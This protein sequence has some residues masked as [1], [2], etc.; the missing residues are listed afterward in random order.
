MEIDA[1]MQLRKYA[2]TMII[3]YVEDDLNTR[4]EVT[5]GLKKIFR[6]VE[7]ATNTNDGLKLYN[8][9]RHDI[10]ITDIE[11]PIMDGIEMVKQ[12]KIINK[13][14]IVAV[15][16]AY[17]HQKYLLELIEHGVDSFIMKP[18]NIDEFFETIHKLI[19]NK[20]YNNKIEELEKQINE[21]L[22]VEKKLLYSTLQEGE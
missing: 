14:Q 11:M 16:S 18:F 3:L 7:V 19:K 17:D 10:V 20:Y 13:N 6:S 4:N 1:I 22:D 9:S 15:S 21:R 5:R 2:Q 8:K 12:I